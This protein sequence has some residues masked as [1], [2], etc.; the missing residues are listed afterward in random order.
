MASE[1]DVSRV[2]FRV[3]AEKKKRL[4][5]LINLHNALLG[6]EEKVT[7]SDLLRSCMDDLI[8]DL[9]EDLQQ[10]VGALE[11]FL[12]GNPKTAAATAD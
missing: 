11:E 12:E 1:D 8:Q 2:T 9:E 5:D 3:D 7:K 4:E 6:D 10:E